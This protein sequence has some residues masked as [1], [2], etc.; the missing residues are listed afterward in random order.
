MAG[1][2]A[3]ST[4]IRRRC[5]THDLPEYKPEEIQHTLVSKGIPPNEAQAMTEA[6]EKNRIYAIKNQ[7]SP[8]PNFRH[9]I[10]LAEQI[11]KTNALVNEDAPEVSKFSFFS[12]SSSDTTAA[13][14][15]HHP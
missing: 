11:Q 14:L 13:K 6:F 3:V 10:H 2:R 1:R 7:L 15:N 5:I 4:A 8:V 9:L 12:P